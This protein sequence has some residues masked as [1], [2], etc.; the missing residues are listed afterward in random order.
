MLFI[1]FCFS[2]RFFLTTE[3]PFLL[4]TLS[5]LIQ[6]ARKVKKIFHCFSHL[7]FCI[8][9]VLLRHDQYEI[10]S[11]PRRS[12]R[13]PYQLP[14]FLFNLIPIGQIVISLYLHPGNPKGRCHLCRVSPIHIQC[15]STTAS[16]LSCAVRRRSRLLCQFSQ[17]SADI[18]QIQWLI[19]A[20]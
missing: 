3:K 19:P 8:R 14:G 17:H 13:Q 20:V 15:C 1:L 12:D 10:A 18:H 16:D 9:Q 6:D 2:H 11:R 4:Q 7:A 5:I